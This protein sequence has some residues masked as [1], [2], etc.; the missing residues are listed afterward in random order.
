MP[1]MNAAKDAALARKKLWRD[2]LQK[3]KS[4]LLE[5]LISKTTM[6]S[7]QSIF[8]P[9]LVEECLSVGLIIAPCSATVE[10]VGRV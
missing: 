1:G 2:L 6:D 8:V 9:D 7:S 3:R 5:T 4:H 10:P